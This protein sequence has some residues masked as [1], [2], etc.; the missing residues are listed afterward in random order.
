MTTLGL[1]SPVSRSGALSPH[2]PRPAFDSEVLRAYMKKLLPAT[3]SHAV[4]SS[5]ERDQVKAWMKE[6]GDRVKERM[7]LIQ[8]NGLYV[9]RLT[10]YIYN[11]AL[12]YILTQQVYCLGPDHRK[13]GAGWP[14]GVVCSL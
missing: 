3:L 12:S 10:D 7:V 8:P 11:M 1:R 9:E 14:V 2:P 13:Y 6:I 4:W 5:I